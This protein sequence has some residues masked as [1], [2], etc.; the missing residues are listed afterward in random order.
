[1]SLYGG[2]K[3]SGSK[4]PTASTSTPSASTPATSET[5][6]SPSPVDQDKPRP[7]NWS[8]ALRFAPTQR[9]K[10]SSLASTSSRPI[11]TAF[12][13]SLDEDDETPIAPSTNATGVPRMA[14]VGKSSLN[15]EPIKRPPP[16]KWGAASSMAAQEAILLEAKA[17]AA[18]AAAAAANSSSNSTNQTNFASSSNAPARR[19]GAPTRIRRIIPIPPSMTLEDETI[20]PTAGSA[21][22]TD[23]NGFASTAMG[24]KLA[25]EQEK[26]NNKR[27]KKRKGQGGGGED[28]A[29][30][31][32]EIPYDPA[33]PCDYAGYKTHVKLM[34]AQRRL[35][36]E[37]EERQR[38]R[39][40][41]SGSGSSYYSEDEEDEREDYRDEP[42]KR[43]RYFAPPT[44]YD[45]EG[46]SAFPPPTD[47]DATPFTP[48]PSLAAP[49]REETADEAYARRVAMSNPVAPKREE[50]GDEAYQRRLALSQR[51]PPSFAAAER[52]EPVSHRGIGGGLGSNSAP[53]T[54]RAPAPP[55]FITS[56]FVPPTSFVPS[57][58]VAPSS[59]PPTIPPPPPG[60]IPPPSFASQSQPPPPPPDVPSVPTPPSNAEGSSSAVDAAAARA[61]EIAARLSKLGGAFSAGPPLA[62][63]TTSSAPTFQP[64]QASA[65][66]ETAE[67]DNR[68]FAER[69]MSKYGWTSGKGLG[70]SESG[71][72]TALSVSRPSPSAPKLSR[73]QKK[74][75]KHFGIEGTQEVA[76]K[77]GMAAKNNVIDSSRTGRA[78][79][80]NKE[81]GGEPSRV[82]LLENICGPNEVDDE[83]P[84][85]IAEEA[86]KLGVVE[87][88][89]VVIVPFEEEEVGEAGEREEVRVFLVMSGLAGAYNAVRSFEG[90]FFGGRTVRARYYGEEAFQAGEHYL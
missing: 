19:T 62:Q 40:E 65:S 41:G 90:R 17:K 68:P 7:S 50:T 49:S 76:S 55:S 4:L 72:T 71:M 56:S 59:L 75:Q 48:A 24:Q 29:L 28:P 32:G 47:S 25:K 10:P 6:A 54:S 85:E 3:L 53:S 14:K 87:R 39:R 51:P 52:E 82:V 45:D 12:S 83:L 73:A 77:G 11:S 9:K 89:A 5:K 13:T 38:R 18:A 35:E 69:M 42:T 15:V 31:Y 64:A 66:S 23:V 36:R 37:E 44:S 27:G 30:R 26:K 84:G 70:A 88:C 58:T 80:R 78:E 43:A 34:R 86:N 60:F 81:M 2:I 1:M 63:T 61:R 33:R 22:G 46:P 74:K 21:A 16:S 79:E 20:L 8:A 57:T 67:P